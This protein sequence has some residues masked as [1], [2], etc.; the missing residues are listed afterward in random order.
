MAVAPSE[1][2]VINIYKSSSPCSPT[3]FMDGLRSIYDDKKET[4]IVGD[5]NICFREEN[6]H[7]IIKLMKSM[8]F[9]QKIRL[10]THVQGRCIDHVYHYLPNPDRN[11]TS[12]EV[13]QF[14]QFY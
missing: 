8:N 14:G 9:N 11:K 10:P 13:L 7:Q 1:L 3:L 2:N 4:I 12:V 5:F 6:N